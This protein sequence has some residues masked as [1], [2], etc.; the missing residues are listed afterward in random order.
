MQSRIHLQNGWDLSLRATAVTR[1]LNGYRKKSQHRKLTLAKKI[2]PPLL[3]RRDPDYS[4]ITAS[5]AL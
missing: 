4:A 5:L 1:G 2:L 3:P